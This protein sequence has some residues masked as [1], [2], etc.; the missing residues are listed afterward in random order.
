[1]YCHNPLLK[2]RVATQIMTNRS[3]DIAGT[4]LATLCCLWLCREATRPNDEVVIV[5]ETVVVP[6]QMPRT[7]TKK[8]RYRNRRGYYDNRD[9]PTVIVVNEK[10]G[11]DQQELPLVACT[12]VEMK[13]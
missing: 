12:H 4:I 6:G 11:R 2:I 5:E 7:Y 9:D 8:K 10:A 3:S 1:M 13:R